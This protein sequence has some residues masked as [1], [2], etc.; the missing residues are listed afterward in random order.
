M[1]NLEIFIDIGCIQHVL[2]SAHPLITCIYPPPTPVPSEIPV[3]SEP[4]YNPGDLSALVTWS[5]IS[6]DQWNGV[7]LNYVV[8]VADFTAEP[9]QQHSFFVDVDENSLLINLLIVSNTV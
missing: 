4:V 2:P 5:P 1:F 9:V 6:D 8:V 7:M 3:V